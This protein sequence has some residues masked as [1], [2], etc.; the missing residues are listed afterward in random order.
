MAASSTGSRTPSRRR[1]RSVRVTVS[2]SLLAVATVAVL[3]TLPTQSPVWLSAG[4]VTGLVL[5]WAALRI[6]WT[7]VLQSRRENAA[8]RAAA[9]AAYRDLFSVRAAEHA[10]FTTAMTERLAEAHL[11]QRELEGMVVQHQTRASRAESRLVAESKAL[12]TAQDRLVELEQ[13][14]VVRQAEE[15]DALAT[16][17]AD[18]GDSVV[19]LAAW[20]EQVTQKAAQK[21]SQTAAQKKR[22]RLKQA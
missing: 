2:V 14:L 18:G 1:Q 11:S 17:E 15:A 3:A 16:W 13:A 22:Q 19:A 4:S 9:A 7:E 6:M 12:L 20:D 5:A 10:E 8:D 21:S